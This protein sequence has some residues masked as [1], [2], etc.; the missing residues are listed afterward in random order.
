MGLLRPTPLAVKGNLSAYTLSAGFG[1][2]WSCSSTGHIV[3]LVLPRLGGPE[4][5]FGLP[6]CGG[7]EGLF[8]SRLRSSYTSQGH[9]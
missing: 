7:L 5:A 6:H 2:P 8:Q 9:A 1:G 4:G 3:A